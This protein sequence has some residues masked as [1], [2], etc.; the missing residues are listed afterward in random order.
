MISLGSL[1]AKL[2]GR[3]R[4][5]IPAALLATLAIAL[6]VL[7]ATTGG[8]TGNNDNTLTLAKPAGVVEGTFML[9]NIVVRGD[10]A[11]TITEP[12][13]GGWTLVAKRTNANGTPALTQ[14]VYYKVAGNSEGADY[15][16]TFGADSAAVGGIV[17]YDDI[18]TANPIIASATNAVNDGVATTGPSAPSVD[19]TPVDYAR[20]VALYALDE[21][22]DLTAP[23]G[24]TLSFGAAGNYGRGGNADNQAFAGAAEEVQAVAGA[25]TAKVASLGSDDARYVAQTV[26]LRRKASKLAF[27][28]SPHSGL[29][30]A[31]F[32]PITVQTRG[33]SGT[34]P[35]DVTA[36]TLVDVVTDGT[37]SF[38]SEAT[39]TTG[40]TVGDR[41]IPSG[42]NQFTF[43]YKPTLTGDGSHELMASATGLA[44][45]QQTQT[46][47]K[48]N[49][50][51]TFTQPASPQT[52]N[53]TFNVNPTSDS[54]LSV[55]LG[56][57]GGCTAAPDSSPPGYD[58]TMTSGTTAC[59]LTASQGGNDDYNAASNV[60]RNVAAAKAAQT[61]TFTQPASPQMFGTTFHVDPTSNSNLAVSLADGGNSEGC[62]AVAALGG[63]YD[64]TIT[65]GDKDC[66]LTA[67][68]IG[69]ANF[70]AATP[71]LRT[72]QTQKANQTITFTQP[73]SPQTYGTTFD[74]DPTS[75]STLQVAL[76][77][78]GG[79]G[80]VVDRLH[81]LP[82]DTT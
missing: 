55:S 9:A 13:S 53:T 49:Q 47:N 81:P 7:A 68:Q 29:K 38:F 27:A 74:V 12:V 48:L 46:V 32:G 77:A 35:V 33:A 30:N 11:L 45:A 26:A 8:T 43:Y 20:V 14:A 64:V 73:A 75:D 79:C 56:A 17:T 21:N 78:T 72:V 18:D 23:A 16:W 71:V 28:T 59:Q 61:I 66:N 57:S 6:P 10:S 40:L 4:L 3:S 52:Y 80:S 50:I 19:T 69:D 63:G 37:G 34:D 76:L 36:D 62:D 51:I 54:G 15:T 60:I 24:M 2:A 39:C 42:S 41:T 82:M 67:T 31:C 44:S 22:N 5:A 1:F 58:V 65:K 25:S 70:A